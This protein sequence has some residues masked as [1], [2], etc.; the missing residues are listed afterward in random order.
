MKN[1][2]ADSVLK[3]ALYVKMFKHL[4]FLTTL[5]VLISHGYVFQPRIING[6]VC[7][8]DQYPFFVK[9][10]RYVYDDGIPV[11]KFGCGGSLLTDR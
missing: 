4:L 10:F 5:P 3:P 8:P 7:E 9:L 6:N 2:K 1:I 11:S